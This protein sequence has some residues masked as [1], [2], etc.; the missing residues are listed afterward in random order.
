MSRRPSRYSR[1][2]TL[3]TGAN[4]AAISDASD[5]RNECVFYGVTL[6]G[7]YIVRAHELELWVAALAATPTGNAGST[8]KH[9]TLPQNSFPLAFLLA[10]TRLHDLV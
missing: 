2:F 1:L 3:I 4:P 9:E 10:W 5:R 7:S 8:K 6:P